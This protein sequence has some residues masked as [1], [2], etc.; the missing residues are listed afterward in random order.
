MCCNISFFQFS[1]SWE[2]D[3][4]SSTT[5]QLATIWP[6]LNTLWMSLEFIYLM[7]L[8]LNGLHVQS[9][10]KPY[11]IALASFCS[12]TCRASKLKWLSPATWGYIYCSRLFFFNKF[13][14]RLY[15]FLFYLCF[16]NIEH[17]HYKRI[18]NEAPAAHN[19]FTSFF[20]KVLQFAVQIKR[21]KKCHGLRIVLKEHF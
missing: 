10:L 13:L 3:W 14:S 21:G 6:F 8:A 12:N 7:E 17:V 18:E 9:Q 11:E 2:I 1:K 4:A 15:L 19:V 20:L 5:M 16:F